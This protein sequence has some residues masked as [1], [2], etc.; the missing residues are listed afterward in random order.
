MIILGIM[1]LICVQTNIVLMLFFGYSEWVLSPQNVV[2]MI[3][4]E[5][6]KLPTQPNGLSPKTLPEGQKIPK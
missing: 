1:G 2:G 3:A 5:C 4:A 6:E